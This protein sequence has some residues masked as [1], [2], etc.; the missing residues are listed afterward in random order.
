M[1]VVTCGADGEAFITAIIILIIINTL[2][3]IM[4]I[5]HVQNTLIILNNP[6]Q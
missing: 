2:I 4:P 3:I 1:K 5:N 6:I